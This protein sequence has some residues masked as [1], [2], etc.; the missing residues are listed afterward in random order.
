MS[1]ANS[2][3]ALTALSLMRQ[4]QEVLCQL[5]KLGHLDLIGKLLTE[6]GT[7]QVAHGGNGDIYVTFCW[8]GRKKVKVA[9][10]RLRFYI[11]KDREFAK[12]CR[13]TLITLRLHSSR[14]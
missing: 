2:G 8:I 7:V 1:Q 13:P 11:Y 10:K 9:L 12:V 4:S 14:A 6:D 3:Q 5:E